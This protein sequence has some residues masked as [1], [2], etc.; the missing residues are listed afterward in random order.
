[1]LLSRSER[2]LATW[3]WLFHAIGAAVTGV[4]LLGTVFL[5]IQPMDR[6]ESDL[7]HQ[8][9][10]LTATLAAED[11][12]TAEHESLVAELLAADDMVE[13]LL[14]RIP[15]VPRESDFLGQITT[16]ADEVGLSIVDYRPG[17]ATEKKGY[18]QMTLTLSSDGSYESVCNFLHQIH[19]LPRLSRVLA[20]DIAPVADGDVYKMMMT[21]TIFFAPD[22]HLSAERPE[23]DHV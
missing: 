17:S 1:M 23:H 9:A 4:L 19:Q 18:K 14:N 5:V 13:K 21:L 22:S 15:A 7:K 11:A 20:L 16:L 6:R 8:A 12:V 10:E 3:S 2:K